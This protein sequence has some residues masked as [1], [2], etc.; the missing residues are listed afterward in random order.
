[1]TPYPAATLPRPNAAHLPLRA[2]VENVEAQSH[3]ESE[4]HERAESVR[5]H[6]AKPEQ[7][8]YGRAAAGAAAALVP[9]K[10]LL[11]HRRWNCELPF[12]LRP[13]Q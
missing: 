1:M 4:Q 8:C 6:E 9:G 5:G 12:A 7:A 10:R 11:L 2:G 13:D 3:Y